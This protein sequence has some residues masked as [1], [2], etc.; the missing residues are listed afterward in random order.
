M[1]RTKIRTPR[2]K[3]EALRLPNELGM[4]T[5]AHRAAVEE[6]D[7]ELAQ[8]L[9]DQMKKYERRG[10]VARIEDIPVEADRK[11][12][13]G[14]GHG[15]AQPKRLI[16]DKQAALIEI[17]LEKL[18]NAQHPAY[19]IADPWYRNTK[20]AGK[21]TA[22]LA[23]KTITRLKEHLGMTVGDKFANN[24]PIQAPETSAEA[25]TPA[26][27]TFRPITLPDGYYAIVTDGKT[28]F[29]RVSTWETRDGQKRRKMQEQASDTLHKMYWN[30]ALAI[31]DLINE[32]GVDASQ[33][34]YATELGCCYVCGRTLTDD[35]SRALGIGP[36]CRKGR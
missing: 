33:K 9:F 30:N 28:H 12:G 34:L 15:H 36:M 21:M 25:V 24:T 29:Y 23:S 20:R 11:P 3:V 14:Y 4:L 8:T 17:L 32:V 22:E 1:T 10:Q 27:R 16:T 5:E 35:T 13:N 6:G 7:I 2:P 19:Q 31:Q 18:G 26:P